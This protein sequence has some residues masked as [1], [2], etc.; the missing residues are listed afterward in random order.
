MA[1]RILV[2]NPGTTSTKIALYEND[3]ELF[4][5][6]VKHSSDVLSK[7]KTIAEQLPYR[8]ESVNQALQENNVSIDNLSAVVSQCGGVYPCE[9]GVYHVSETL[10]ADQIRGAEGGQHPANLG[11]ALAESF[12]KKY[13]G[14]AFVV[15]PPTTDEFISEAH[16][17]GMANVIRRSRVHA[18]NIKAAAHRAS[19]EM[20]KNYVECNFV[21]CHMGGGTTVGAQRCGRLIDAMDCL[22]GDGAFAA[23]RAGAIPAADIVKQCFSGD[24]TFSDMMSRLMKTGGLVEHLGTS[25]LQDVLK[26]ISDGDKYAKLV[27]DGML[28]QVCKQIGAYAASLSM[29]VDGVILT[30][31]MMNSSYVVEYIV[32]HVNKIARIF[33]YPGEFEMEAMRDGAI[34]VLDGKEIG[35]TYESKAPANDLRAYIE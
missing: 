13:G 10:I 29:D 20:G 12:A 33:V 25:S 27:L 21:I 4:S 23:T 11:G 26:M 14:V 24:Y 30:G 19:D 35:Q 15:D 34:R 3:K 6:N 31:G 17:T 1:Y 8:V 18:L 5:T 22:M 16:V 32:S 2:L 28:Y 7:Y 9:G